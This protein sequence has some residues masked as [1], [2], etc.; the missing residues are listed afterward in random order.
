MVLSRLFSTDCTDS[1]LLG[2]GGNLNSR[3]RW[4]Q[5]VPSQ[6]TRWS[7]FPLPSLS[8]EKFGFLYDPMHA[9]FDVKLGLMIV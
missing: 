4:S 1:L 3:V 8:M 7:A 2:P 5:M 9:K 6:F